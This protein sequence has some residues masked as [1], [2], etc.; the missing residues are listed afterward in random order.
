MTHTRTRGP[1]PDGRSRTRTCDIY[2]VNVA[3][4]QLSYATSETA[5]VQAKS[6]NLSRIP[7]RG[8]EP[9]SPP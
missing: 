2:D 6:P 3:L 8:L 1:G 9:R 4:Y 7:L 5:E